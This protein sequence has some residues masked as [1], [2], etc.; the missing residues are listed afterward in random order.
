MILQIGVPMSREKFDF[1]FMAG[2]FQFCEGGMAG[3][4][5]VFIEVP[6]VSVKGKFH[7]EFPRLGLPDMA[8]M[9]KFVQ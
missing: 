9:V 8:K 3:L 4:G 6:V 2:L 5:S 7:G 1:I